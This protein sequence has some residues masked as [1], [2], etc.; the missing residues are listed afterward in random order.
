VFSSWRWPG[1]HRPSKSI[2]IH[3]QPAHDVVHLRRCRNADRLPHQAVDAGASRHMRPLDCLGTA[4]TDGG[5]CWI[6]MTRGRA[7]LIGIGGRQTKGITQRCEL[8]AYLI[9]TAAKDLR[10]HRSR[11]MSTGMPE[12]TG[13]GCAANTRPHVV[14]LGFTCSLPVDGHL[15][16]M[17]RAQPCGVD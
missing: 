14:H 9:L 1:L 13:G 6:K 7:P 12:P 8:E 10:S 2:S 16:R 3:Q 17:Q 11:L 15:V 4:W 5:L